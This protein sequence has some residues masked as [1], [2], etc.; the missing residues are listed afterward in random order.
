MKRKYRPAMR[1]AARERSQ[2]LDDD[3]EETRKWFEEWAA[4]H[5]VPEQKTDDSHVEM[6]K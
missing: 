3:A 6:M 2:D 4:Q 5:E 1:A